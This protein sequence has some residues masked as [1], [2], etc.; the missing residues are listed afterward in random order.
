[1]KKHK[2]KMKNKSG[3]ELLLPIYFV[4]AVLPFITRM[5][6]YDSGLSQ[7]E[8]CSRNGIVTDF[9]TYYKSYAFGFIGVIAGILLIILALFFR[10]SC[11]T[12]R[13]FLPIGIYLVF[14]VL[15][16]VFS[17]DPHTSTVGAMA[18][19]E[20]VLVLL[21]YVIL[22]TYAYQ[23]MKTEDD[24]RQ[25]R[26][27][28]FVSVVLMCVVGLLQMIGQDPM[29][30]RWVQKM[31]IPAEYQQE[32]LGELRSH[33]TANAVSL[34]LF[35]ANFAAVYLVMVLAFFLPALAHIL[36]EKSQ[37][38]T[39]KIKPEAD[40]ICLKEIRAQR[41]RKAGALLFL[42][43]LLILITKTYSRTALVAIFVL[44][45]LFFWFYRS[46]LK[47]LCMP[48]VIG[49]LISGLVFVGVDSMSQFRFL[50]KITSSVTNLFRSES[51]NA[52]G[53]ILTN[54]DDVTIQYRGETLHVAIADVKAERPSLIFYGEDD[55][56]L[57]STYQAVTSTLE[58][59]PFQDISFSV[60]Q[61]GV[62]AYIVATIENTTWRFC[63][64]P[65]LGYVYYND[66]E[67]TDLLTETK[68]FGF[69]NHE[70]FA[71]GRGY[72]WSR[73]LPILKQ[74]LFLGTGPDTF[75]LV[76]PQSDYVGK[77]NNCKTAFTIIE[78]PHSLYLGM[79][80]QTGV[81][82]LLAFLCFIILYL[83]K[84]GMIYRKKD[85]TNEMD[86]VG[87]GC[88]LS[89][90]V[91]L[92]CGFFNDSSLQTSPIFWVMIGLGMAANR[93]TSEDV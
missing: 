2:Q 9:F 74:T 87:L 44:L 14:V 39:N 52:L 26:K 40:K 91:Y 28:Y 29:I 70:D 82:S 50:T 19:F 57:T 76:F 56:N 11:R 13:D 4:L 7:Y 67:R 48:L 47:K 58:T 55:N 83:R 30:F 22:C 62:T 84:S 31:V 93:M 33:T 46:Q 75:L 63:Y 86:Q 35:N 1:M 71:S 49:V 8:W 64:E 41:L 60:V 88:F 90:V 20:N 32:Y 65:G 59:E 68:A 61:D 54:H 78:K 81:V 27:V 17:V 34:T 72:I 3:K 45:I 16:T 89:T 42:G 85:F 18:H 12:M 79:G 73:S 6:Q 77:A 25:I 38:K 92:V 21:G 10:E 23:T 66:F 43:V 51:A 80:I 53:A 36:S 69:Q 5:L 24:F 15:S 37:P